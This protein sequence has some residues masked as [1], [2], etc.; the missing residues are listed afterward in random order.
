MQVWRPAGSSNCVRQIGPTEWATDLT[1]IFPYNSA[2]MTRSKTSTLVLALTGAALTVVLTGCGIPSG[3]ASPTASPTGTVT[4]RTTTSF[5]ADTPTASQQL[6]K[7]ITLIAQ[8]GEPKDST[9]AGLAWKG[10]QAAAVQA[11]ATST[12]VQPV[13]NADFAKEI[14]KA[15][16]DGAV[17][18][19][20]GSDA[21][22]AMQAAAGAHAGTQFVELGVA[23]PAASPDNLHGIVFDEAEAGYLGGYVAASFA[24]SGKIG[25]V[26]DATTDTHSINYANG[27]KAGASQAS[28]GT[29]A[30]FAY[31]GTADSPDKGRTAAA[32]LVAAGDKVIMATPSLSGIGALREACAHG[33]KVVAVDTDAAQTIPDIESCLIVSVLSRYDVAVSDAI[34][35]LAA[36][37]ALPRITTSDV[38][39]G[40][41]TLSDFHASL[42][43]GFQSK[44][45]AVMAALKNRAGQPT[46]AP[47]GS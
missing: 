10:V 35:A 34:A 4:A 5:G 40:G 43:A 32:G 20:V 42:P 3:A 38:A 29:A 25:M 23:V 2:T 17:V 14:D 7:S 18:V 28:P 12:L 9:P 16:G 30:G 31:V 21:A 13:S 45:D 15:A 37:T 41:I 1:P 27:F 44:L 8:I 46:P 11:G 6:V 22:A 47:S 24:T 26:G 36:G 33:A 19:T 39:T